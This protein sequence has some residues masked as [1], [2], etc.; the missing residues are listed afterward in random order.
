MLASRGRHDFKIGCNSH[1]SIVNGSSDNDMLVPEGDEFAGKT[2]G[3]STGDRR[4]DKEVFKMHPH[5]RGRS[6]IWW[7]AIADA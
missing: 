5:H 7:S 6:Q 1:R 2:I 3:T 4:L